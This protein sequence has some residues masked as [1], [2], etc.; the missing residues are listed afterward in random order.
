[1]NTEASSSHTFKQ[2][3]WAIP[4][5]LCLL[6]AGQI[7]AAWDR[8]FY[9]E[10]AESIRNVYWLEQ[11]EIYD[12]VSSNIGWYGLLLFVYKTFGFSLH[13]AKIV[14]L[15]LYTLAIFSMA[16]TLKQC[17]GPKKSILPLVTLGLSPT[18][19]YFNTY[20][21]TYGL[22]ITYLALLSGL[23]YMLRTR[24]NAKNN[25]AIIFGLGLI[26][27]IAASTYPT[28]LLYLPFILLIVLWPKSEQKKSWKIIFKQTS[29]FSTAFALPLLSALLYLHEP[30]RLFYDAQS[31]GTGLFRAGG[32]QLNFD[33]SH[34]MNNLTQVAKDLFERGSSYYFSMPYPEFGGFFSWLSILGVL[35]ILYI[36]REQLQKQVPWF[37]IGLMLL[38]M[39]ALLPNLASVFPGLRRC[40]GILVG[41]YLIYL[42]SSTFVWNIPKTKL[43]L[44]CMLMLVG[45]P[46]NH[47]VAY[48]RNLA[49]L[50]IEY[51]Y[52]NYPLLHTAPTPSLSLEKWLADTSQGKIIDCSKEVPTGK[53][54][55][56]SE[57]FS[58]IQGHRLWNHGTNVPLYAKP[59]KHSEKI[60][61]NLDLWRNYTLAH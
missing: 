12:G 3:F 35:G 32:M 15:V 30:M 57:I 46:V 7:Y 49:Q 54:C 18:W 24:N 37:V 60:Q 23:L 44:F 8:L 42:L 13:I 53:P 6:Q 48:K 29:C 10:I 40:T 39:S 56:L 25:T 11:K 9:E 22:D 21:T 4:L 58:C 5:L 47:L 61:L 19:L 36:Q 59:P 50:N 27:S 43:R 28:F 45:L 20:Q 34:I 31:K 1:V 26:S 33:L 55:K 38:I 52:N 16:W 51:Q 17:F 2:F 14:R 41:F